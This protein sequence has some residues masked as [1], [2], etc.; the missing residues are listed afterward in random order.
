MR[1]CR[2]NLIFEG[3]SEIMRLFIAREAL[4]PHLKKLRALANPPA[5][6]PGKKIGVA[7]AAALFYAVWY[8]GK[9]LPFSWKKPAHMHPALE[10]HV[11]YIEKT[12]R[13]LAR[14]FFHAMITYGSKLE[15]EQV[16]VSRYVN[17]GTQLFA[18]AAVCARAQA[19]SRRTQGDQALR[20]ADY[21]CRQSRLLVAGFF[22]ATFR[23]N[24]RQ[25]YRLAR[26]VLEGAYEWLEEGALG[27]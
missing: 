8:P 17:V 4:D 27:I 14:T 5:L 7:G 25:G 11:S 13:K 9:W 26:Q 23:N 16:L 19:L 3:S 24:D 21:F 1:D 2:I 20:L 12:S 10:G 22:K 15:R 18:M 6:S